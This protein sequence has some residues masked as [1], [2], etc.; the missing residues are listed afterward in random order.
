MNYELEDAI[1]LTLK[2]VEEKIDEIWHKAE[3]EEEIYD[4]MEILEELKKSIRS[5]E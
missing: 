4:G 2:K 5:E 1:D 3:I